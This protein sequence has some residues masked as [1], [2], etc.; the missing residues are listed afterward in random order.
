MKINDRTRKILFGVAVVISFSAIYI[1][2][3][4]TPIMSDDLLFDTGAYHSV[5][6]II[7]AEYENYM[8]WNGRTVVQLIMRGCLL[9]VLFFLGSGYVKSR[10]LKGWMLA[11]PAGMF[12]GLGFMVMA[13]GNR[14]RSAVVMEEEEHQGILA[15][16]AGSLRSIR[17]PDSIFCCWG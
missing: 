11:G 10:T 2:N 17:R 4:L 13:P 14:I 5:T 6:D 7:R 12:T 16:A 3:C 15:L 9:L 8:N 1:Y